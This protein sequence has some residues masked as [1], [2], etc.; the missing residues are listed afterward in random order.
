MY[1]YQERHTISDTGI[2]ILFF[3]SSF[4][5]LAIM[6]YALTEEN[7]TE[8][9][10]VTEL[11]LVF[12]LVLVIQVG[13]Y[14]LVFNTPLEIKVSAAGMHYKYFPFVWKEK[15]ISF[16]E[17]AEWHMRKISPFGE[18]GGWGYRKKWGKNKATGLVLKDGKGI[19]LKKTDGKRL[20]FSSANAE[21]FAIALRK[22]ISIKEKHAHG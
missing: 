6:L 13:V 12:F 10:S 5:T 2:R 21:M 20:V 15:T 22:Y 17:I 18:F 14:F 3:S 11:L 16:S 7:K 19:E 8:G 9:D 4:I 1:D